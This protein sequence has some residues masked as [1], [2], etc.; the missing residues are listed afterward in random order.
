MRPPA[1]RVRSVLALAAVGAVLAGS[2]SATSGPAAAAVRRTTT[3]SSTTTTAPA[4]L[5]TGDTATFAKGTGGW[6]PANAT[7]ARTVVDGVAALKVTTVAAGWSM[8]RSGRQ[9]AVVVGRTYTAKVATRALTTGRQAVPYVVFYD[10]AGAVLGEAKGT[11][12]TDALGRWTQVVP[13]VAVA[14]AG[15]TGVGVGLLHWGT[16]AGEAHVLTSPVL[17][18]TTRV[19]RAVVGP[20]TTSGNTLRDANGPLVLR[21]L[22]R[23]GLETTGTA[24]TADEV[25][26]ARSWG[27]NVLRLN[28]SGPLYT[29]GDCAYDAAYARSVDDAV[30]TITAAGLVAL[31]DLHTSS[32]FACGRTKQQQ[33]ADTTSLAFWQQAAARHA[34]NPLVMFDLY[35]EPHDIS[36]DVWLHGGTVTTGTLDWTAVGMQD[37]Y[38]AVRST[39]ATNVVVASGN[40]WANRLPASRI[41]GYGVVYGVHAYTCPVTP[42]DCSATPTDPTPILSSWAVP[43]QSVPVALTEFGYPSQ[44]DGAA[45]V[46]NAI[47]YA[48][49]HGWG[50][51]AFAWDGSTGSP[52]GLLAS[53][54]TGLPTPSGMPVV[55]ALTKN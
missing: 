17:T 33:M 50:W 49:A 11:I 20:L 51:A 39:G 4:N 16:A 9:T 25:R 26:L 36:D 32:P 34:S 44:A 54:T 46:G 5:L 47:S 27:A 55:T 37:L 15:A 43:S 41:T 3:T 31:L 18:A 10:S 30:G 1:S 48:E 8:V 24:P 52:F 35:N 53:S 45:Y 40:D 29:A 14:P 12:A 38:D 13:A 28:V 19:G 21:G 2:V 6:V 22:N 7:I 23:A 42:T